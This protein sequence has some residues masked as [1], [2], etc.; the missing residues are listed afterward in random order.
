MPQ[1]C[2]SMVLDQV[3]P[4]LVRALFFINYDRSTIEIL[5]LSYVVPPPEPFYILHNFIAELFD[6]FAQQ[7]LAPELWRM[8]P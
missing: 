8:N 4:A 5:L 1:A 2:K 3:R 6:D 7:D